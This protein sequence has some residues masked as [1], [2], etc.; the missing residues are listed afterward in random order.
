MVSYF[1]HNQVKFLLEEK[2]SKQQEKNNNIRKEEIFILKP[3]TKPNTDFYMTFVNTQNK[4]CS[5]HLPPDKEYVPM[6][7]SKIIP[8]CS[9]LPKRPF[10]I[11]KFVLYVKSL[12]YF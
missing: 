3:P 4:L 10:L 8:V 2:T 12:P 1:I 6:P 7:F 11:R 5:I 9:Y